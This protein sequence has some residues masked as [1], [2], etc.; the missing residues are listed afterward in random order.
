MERLRYY[1]P[2]TPPQ[3]IAGTPAIS[4]PLGTSAQGLPVGVQFASAMG[5]ERSLLEIAF[6]LEAQTPWSYG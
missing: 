3:N 1:T 5:D 2:F 6:E 4:L